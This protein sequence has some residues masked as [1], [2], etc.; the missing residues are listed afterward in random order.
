VTSRQLRERLYRE[1]ERNVA[2]R[3]EDTDSP[4]TFTVSGR[5]ELHLGILMETMRR[6]GYEFAVSRPRIITRR[7]P[8]GELLEP[9]EEATIDVPERFVGAVIEKLGSRRGTLQEMRSPET[10]ADGG[11][12]SGLVRLVFRVPAR[13]LFGYRNEFLTDTRGEGILHHRF[14]EYEQWAG[15]IKGRERGVMVSMVDG[16][17]VA[18]ALWN[19]QERGTLFI[20][21]G[22]ETYEG[23]IVGENARPGDLE[24]NVAKGKK[25]TNIRAA[26]ADDAIMLETPRSLTLE[27]GLEF[28]GDDELM[29]V[30]P[31][32]IRL[33]KRHLK[34]HERKKASRAAG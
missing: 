25:L 20:G 13:G 21:P 11:Q 10:R 12:G 27:R 1:L 23:M 29:E 24:V 16:T 6:E 9:Y 33:R 2:L 31:T 30:T 7:G 17:S 15:P 22:V 4:D 19:L 8:D 28:L 18:Y 34:Q 14:F 26:G 32:A 3:V 5:G